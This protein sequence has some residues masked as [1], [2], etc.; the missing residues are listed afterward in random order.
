MAA[1]EVRFSDD[2]RQKMFAG[3]NTLANAVKVTLGPKG[4]NVVI[5]KSFGAPIV[6]DDGVTIAKEF[7]LKEREEDMGAQLLRQAAER[8]G[9]AV[10]D[11]FV[12][13]QRALGGAG[14]GFLLR[15]LRASP[16]L[17]A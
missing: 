11:G 7:R 6:C 15:L 10:G 3:V 5:Q 8:T 14:I 16:E 1:K 12:R 2:A 13:G 4:R 17:R 9:D